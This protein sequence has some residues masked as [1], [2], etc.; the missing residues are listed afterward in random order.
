MNRYGTPMET[1]T[2]SI[3]ETLKYETIWMSARQIADRY[4]ANVTT[5][6][7]IATGMICNLLSFVDIIERR[8]DLRG[9]RRYVVFR[10][11]RG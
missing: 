9:Q 10:L 1:R 6:D 3:L 11:K 2:K 4:L 7:V 8:Q 5:S